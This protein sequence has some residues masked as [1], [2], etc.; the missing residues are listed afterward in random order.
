MLGDVKLSPVGRQPSLIFC[1]CIYLF[2]YIL[3]LLLFLL[4]LQLALMFAF[5]VRSIY[6]K[7]ERTTK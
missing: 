3:L 2:L 5:Y 1:F 4:N 7:E 6:A